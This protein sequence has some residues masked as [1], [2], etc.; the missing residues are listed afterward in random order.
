MRFTTLEVERLIKANVEITIIPGQTNE[1]LVSLLA[2][3]VDPK[4]NARSLHAAASSSRLAPPMEPAGETVLPKNV[5]LEG[6]FSRSGYRPMM[7]LKR[8]LPEDYFTITG[9]LEF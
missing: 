6:L 3:G 2:S 5:T 4:P 7:A 8:L 9:L 1:T